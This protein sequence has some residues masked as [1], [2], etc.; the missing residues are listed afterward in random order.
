MDQE[1]LPLATH[2]IRESS[3]ILA[4]R[5]ISA[6]IIADIVYIIVAVF[7]F[8]RVIEVNPETRFSL[9]AMITIAKTILQ[10]IFIIGI[11]AITN[12]NNY[13]LSEDQLIVHRGVYGRD[14]KVYDVHQIKAVKRHESWLGKLIGYGDLLLSFAESS[15]REDVKLNNISKVKKYENIFI[16]I[17]KRPKA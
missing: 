5:I 4:L 10:S 13:Y 17:M 7:L 12:A 6:L 11:I 8:G 1:N 2:H 9:I 16:E 15:F 14:E 3:S